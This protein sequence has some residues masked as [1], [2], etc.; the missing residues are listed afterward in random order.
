MCGG[1][2]FGGCNGDREDGS[3]QNSL[4]EPVTGVS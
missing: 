4:R 1:D 3:G 2:E